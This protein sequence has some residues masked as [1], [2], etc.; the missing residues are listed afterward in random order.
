MAYD[1]W[2]SAGSVAGR[3]VKDGVVDAMDVAVDAVDVD[4]VAVDVVVRDVDAVVA[5]VESVT[6]VTGGAIKTWTDYESPWRQC[7][8]Y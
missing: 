8:F 4:V 6:E 1:S 7:L 2:E 5:R 3:Q